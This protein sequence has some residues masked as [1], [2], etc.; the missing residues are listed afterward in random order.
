MKRW[1]IWLA[2]ATVSTFVLLNAVPHG[3]YAQ[4][5][6]ENYAV[7]Y[8][9]CTEEYW[10]LPCRVYSRYGGGGYISSWEPLAWDVA[11]VYAEFHNLGLLG[12]VLLVTAFV[13][14]IFVTPG[15]R[16]NAS[17]MGFPVQ[18]LATPPEEK[19]VS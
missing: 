5:F 19:T 1:R 7:R 6:R 11:P 8:G 4:S 3:P 15:R 16:S 2:G 12:N 10:G 17:A 13:F 18:V 14:A 9:S